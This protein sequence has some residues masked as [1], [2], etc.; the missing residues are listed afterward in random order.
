MKDKIKT[1]EVVKD[2][3]VHDTAVNVGDRM[4]NVG[5]KTK[6]TVNENINQADNVSPEQYATDKVSES[7]RTGSETVVSKLGKKSLAIGF[8][9]MQWVKN[10]RANTKLNVGYKVLLE[11]TYVALAGMA[12]TV[13]AVSYVVPQV[14]VLLAHV[15]KTILS[16]Y[17]NPTAV[18][19]T[20][21]VLVGG[22]AAAF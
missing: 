19:A 10:S 9:M 6:D 20:G 12:A 1:R 2:I 3:K 13:V 18:V 4:K 8:A 16:I 7:M 11:I 15:A 14:S 22:L 17:R 21:K 5:V